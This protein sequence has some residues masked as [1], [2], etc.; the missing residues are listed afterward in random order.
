MLE[1]TTWECGILT[2]CHDE[3]VLSSLSWMPLQA[4]GL[5]C[6]ASKPTFS[7]LDNVVFKMS[8]STVQAKSCDFAAGIHHE[9]K[10]HQKFTTWMKTSL[11]IVWK[12]NEADLESRHWF[13]YFDRLHDERAPL[14]KQNLY[15]L[16]LM[17]VCNNARNSSKWTLE[18]ETFTPIRVISSSYYWQKFL[19]KIVQWRFN[20]KHEKGLLTD[21]RPLPVSA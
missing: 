16:T 1:K 7:K 2:R 21:T 13:Q 14:N 5:H 6:A 8:F 4:N 11:P 20:F 12:T 18:E 9:S 17:W 3:K 19:I 15:K 10:K